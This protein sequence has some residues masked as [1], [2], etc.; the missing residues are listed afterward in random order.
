MRQ[1]MHAKNVSSIAWTHVN[2]IAQVAS[3]TSAQLC[4]CCKRMDT[5]CPLSQSFSAW[6]HTSALLYVCGQPYMWYSIVRWCVSSMHHSSALLYVCCKPYMWYS[7]VWFDYSLIRFNQ[8][9]IRFGYGYLRFGQQTIYGS[10]AI[11]CISVCAQ[12]SKWS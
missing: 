12:L 7:I 6:T 1:S 8:V 2:S 11:D 4:V 3:H 10:F 5:S 9:L